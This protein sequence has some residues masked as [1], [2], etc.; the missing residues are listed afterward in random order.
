[1]DKIK[2]LLFIVPPFREKWFF[3]AFFIACKYFPKM[4][5]YMLLPINISQT[6]FCTNKH[7]FTGVIFNL[8]RDIRIN[9]GLPQTKYVFLF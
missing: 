8:V 6:S 3:H 7:I 9:W 4:I 1:M 2:E 5:H